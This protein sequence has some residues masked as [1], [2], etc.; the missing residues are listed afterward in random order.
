MTL[1]L[2]P[3]AGS[4]RDAAILQRITDG[5]YDPI[6][7]ASITSTIEGHTGIFMVFGDALMMDGVRINVSAGVEQKIADALDCLLLTPKLADLIWEQRDCTLAPFPGSTIGMSTTKAM[8]EH[9]AKLDVALA[10][11]TAQ[12]T[13]ISTVGKHWVIDNDLLRHSGMACNYGWH[14]EGPSFQ[15]ITGEAVVT[16]AKDP[17]GQVMRLIQGRGWRHDQHHTDYSQTCVLV[18]KTCTI[19][20]TPMDITDVLQDE[21]LAGLASHE[22]VMC[23]FR[24]PGVA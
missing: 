8:V 13:L 21:A 18:A 7:W 4:E 10:K 14:F 16:G 17:H 1:D 20:G 12:P 19:D 3:D 15:G 5:A 24:Q 9:S 6:K 22:G 23:V 2:P 11:F